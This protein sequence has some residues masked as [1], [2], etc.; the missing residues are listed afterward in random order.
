MT[1]CDKLT[2]FCDSIVH[3]PS[4]RA[5]ATSNMSQPEMAVLAEGG[6]P[7]GHRW[8]LRGGGTRADYC[9]LLEAIYPDGRRDEGGMGG[10][11]LYPGSLMNTS[12]GTSDGGMI[13]ILVRASPRVARVLVQLGGEDQVD[14][15]PVAAR[16]D[17][18]LVFFAT[19]LPPSAVLAAIIAVGEDGQ[20]LESED[21]SGDQ[22]GWRR[23]PPPGLPEA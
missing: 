2:T 1:E 21:V 18:G 11:P 5:G 20:V 23:V 17:L 14:L 4:A 12:T 3:V 22:A 15:P 13:R 10:P 9:T 6:L 19:L 7:A 8:V 16:P